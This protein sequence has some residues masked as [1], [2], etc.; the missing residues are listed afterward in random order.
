MT[1]VLSLRV[2]TPPHAP[3]PVGEIRRGHEPEWEELH[4]FA[5]RHLIEISYFLSLPIQAIDAAMFLY[6]VI[7]VADM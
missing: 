3:G 5:H 4:L 6:H 2:P 1:G 7:I